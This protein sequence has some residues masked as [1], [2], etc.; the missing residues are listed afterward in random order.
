MKQRFCTD[1][2]D[3]HSLLWFN[4]TDHY[5]EFKQPREA[6][7]LEERP[8]IRDL[9]RVTQG[10]KNVILYGPPGTG[11]TYWAQQ[12]SQRFGGNRTVFVTFHQSFPYEEFVEGLKPGSV[13]VK[14]RYDVVPGVF[15]RIYRRAA[16]NPDHEYLLVI[17]E[18]NRA[19]IAKVFGE[20]I[21]LIEDDKRPG[22][23][24]EI[25]VTL[26]YSGELFGVPR[27]LTILGTM[28]T[29]DCSIALLDIALRRRFTFIGVMPNPEQLTATI[30]G[31]SLEK[32]LRRLN[33]QIT[34]ML[35]QDH[36]IGHSYFMGVSNL[37]DLR[38]VW[39]R[40]VQT[41]RPC[42]ISSSSPTASAKP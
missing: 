35:D 33:R 14:I 25:Q 26:P 29:A 41:R 30:Q 27:N 4:Y 34:A 36:Q 5:V 23:E 31:V 7:V 12:Y 22:A 13:E 8:F 21:T 32:L 2:I 28:N 38:F 20:L 1:M 11:K 15:L 3:V 37:A 40:R 16:A 39:R 18:I 6:E 42:A 9:L 24:S 10:T 17:D 19:N